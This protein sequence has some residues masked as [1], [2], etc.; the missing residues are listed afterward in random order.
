MAKQSPVN[1]LT[2]SL[3]KELVQELILRDKKI[4]CFNLQEKSLQNNSAMTSFV[5][6]G[7]NFKD[8]L[9]R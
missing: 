5:V 1:L 6:Q 8:G 2:K 4:H 7:F 9:S 3:K